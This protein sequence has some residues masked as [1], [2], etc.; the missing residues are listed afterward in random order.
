MPLTSYPLIV[1]NSVDSTNNYA[2]AQVHAGLVTHGHAYFA[3]QQTSGKGQRS[4]QWNTGS[5]NIALSIVLQPD[6]LILSEQFLLVMAVALSCY[7]LVKTITGEHTT[8]KWPNDIYWCD[9][10]TGGI[11]IE[12]V[13]QS[14]QWKYAVA[15]IGLNVNQTLF[16]DF[17]PY[18]VSLK[19]V[20]GEDYDVLQMARQLTGLIQNR[21]EQLHHNKTVITDEYNSVLYKLG[22][23]V[24]LKAGNIIFTATVKGVSRQGR[25]IIKNG[26]EKELNW[27]EVEWVNQ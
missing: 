12:N 24:K 9:R 26:V 11:L 17:L 25:L 27:G 14:G 20:T 10:K 18:A 19:Q 2:M 6:R 16:P 23:P 22:K 4:K 5:G 21:Y 7:D 13:I 3:H 15:G 8:I 1:L